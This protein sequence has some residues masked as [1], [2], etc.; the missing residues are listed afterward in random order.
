MSPNDLVS[1]RDYYFLGSE[2]ALAIQSIL[3]TGDIEINLTLI[4]WIKIQDDETKELLF[5][6]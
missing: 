3:L 2:C 1:K 5:N 6:L 4:N